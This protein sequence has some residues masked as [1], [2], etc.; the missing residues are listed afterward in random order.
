[1][2]GDLAGEGGLFVLPIDSFGSNQFFQY[3]S[4]DLPP[5]EGQVSLAL[6]DGFLKVG[7][8]LIGLSQVFV[9][10]IV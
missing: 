8:H 1:M 9:S 5:A 3:L 7:N 10:S 4:K 2:F 6:F